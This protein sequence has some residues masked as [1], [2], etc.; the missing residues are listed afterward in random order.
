[1]ATVILEHH[2]GG[3]LFDI[4]CYNAA[5]Q[6]SAPCL[7]IND[8]RHVVSYLTPDSRRMICVFDAPDAE[9]VRR[10][11]RQLGYRYDNVWTAAVVHPPAVA[12]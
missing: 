1:M 11:A 6:R 8:V 7:A 12:G 5:Q 10:T 9:A 4:D 3:R 2:F